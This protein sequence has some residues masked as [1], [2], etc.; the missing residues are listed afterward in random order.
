MDSYFAFCAET[1]LELPAQT[2]AAFGDTLYR[3]PDGCPDLSGLK[4]LRAGLCLGE[5]RKNRFEPDHALALALRPE[6]VRQS[7]DLPPDGPEVL[8]YLRGETLAIDP[9]LSGYVLVCTG[10]FSLGWGKAAQGILKNHY[11]KGLRRL[12]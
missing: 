6:Q 2:P 10:G 9:A 4:V 5:R 12:G 3:L 11:P 8:R 1:L 7:I